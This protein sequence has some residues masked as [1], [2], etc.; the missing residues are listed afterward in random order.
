[1]SARG[2]TWDT[3]VLEDK[4][5]LR[6]LIGELWRLFAVLSRVTDT[7]EGES[8]FL[9]AKTIQLSH[10]ACMALGQLPSHDEL[11]VIVS[12]LEGQEWRSCG[13]PAK[14]TKRACMSYRIVWKKGSALSPGGP[15][16][17]DSSGL[18]HDQQRR[19]VDSYPPCSRF[20]IETRAHVELAPPATVQR[21][22]GFVVHH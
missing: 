7:D 4:R 6:D 15:K 5:D 20:H 1:M 8:Q 11:L 16:G 22:W 19:G 21:E 14:N 17:R 13:P 9:A 3:P 10:Q 12:F 18:R 2:V